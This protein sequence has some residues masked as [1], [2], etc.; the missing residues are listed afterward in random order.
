MKSSPRFFMTLAVL[1]LSTLFLLPNLKADTSK[2]DTLYSDQIFD[3]SPP[4]ITLDLLGSNTNPC[5]YEC[6]N[7]RIDIHK[8]PDSFID[9]VFTIDA[10]SPSSIGY[11]DLD[12]I[13]SSIG[14]D[15][16][17]S[18]KGSISK[19]LHNNLREIKVS[20]YYQGNRR[21]EIS[22]DYTPDDSSSLKIIPMDVDQS[23]PDYLY[24]R[25]FQTEGTGFFTAIYT[26][27]APETGWGPWYKK[28]EKVK[29][30]VKYRISE[31]CIYSILPFSGL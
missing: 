3:I 8:M 26:L 9:E 29:F 15:H 14:T 20:F 23:N 19:Y 10:T 27:R 2:A 5:Y 6:Y 31:N 25:Y 7:F 11:I 12:A 16:D 22:I 18:T 1:S 24:N 30:I 21:M 4:L 13:D 17:L 28:A